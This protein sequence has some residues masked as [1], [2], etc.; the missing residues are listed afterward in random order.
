MSPDTQLVP[1]S[2]PDIGDDTQEVPVDVFDVGDGAAAGSADDIVDELERLACC[3]KK[4]AAATPS[5][6]GGVTLKRPSAAAVVMKKLAVV[7]KKPAGKRFKL[8]GSRCMGSKIGCLTCRN[9]SYAGLRW[10]K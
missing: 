4:P 10:Q 3:H 6:K 7:T 5:P 2:V 1:T 8:G 9:A